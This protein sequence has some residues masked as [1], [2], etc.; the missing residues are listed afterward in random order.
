MKIGTEK[1]HTAYMQITRKCNNKCIFC[2]NPCFD[3]E[4]DIEEIKKRLSFYKKK[5]VNEIIFSGGEPTE[6][7]LL[8]QAIEMARSYGMY[9]KIITNGVN[10]HDFN[11]AKKLKDA[12]LNH[13]H[14]SI[15]S[16]IEEDSDLITTKEGHFKKTIKGIE[17]CIKI[18]MEININTVINSLN[19]K[20]LSEFV[21]YFIEKFPE[22]KHYVFNNIDA[23]ESDKQIKSRAW[24]N[25]WIISKYSEMEMELS[26]MVAVLKKNFKTCRI[27]RVPLCYMQGFEHLSTET[28]KIVKEEG[29]KCIFIEKEGKDIYVHVKNL[30]GEKEVH[31]AEVCKICFLRDICIGIEK[32]Y[33]QLFGDSDLFPI[34]KNTKNIVKKIKE[35]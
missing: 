28:R 33:Y 18:G 12:G 24:E 15:H 27:E 2:S 4:I 26:K 9:P 5:G 21:K 8:P 30:K 35:E 6:C 7:P 11:Y 17:N 1:R 10:L 3:K 34:F 29:Y 19:A 22:V 13:L 31:K 20:Y 16:H 32:E 23:G 14:I 25:K